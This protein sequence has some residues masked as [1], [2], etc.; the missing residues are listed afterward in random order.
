[1]DESRAHQMAL[2]A[3]YQLDQYRIETELGHGGF[4]ITYRALDTH[5]DREVAIKEYLPRELAYREAG[6]TVRPISQ[7]EQELFEWGLERFL[8]EGRTV[9]QLDH[10]ADLALIRRLADWPRQVEI[11]ARAQE[12]HR[13][14][15]Y[16]SELA[17]DLHT[18]WNRGNDEPGLRFLQDDAAVSGAK[19]AL[20]RATGVVISTGLA[21]LG[22]EPAEEMR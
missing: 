22:V 5:L 14:A 9:A 19:L 6:S 4:G 7:G 8:D 17:G 2:P 12:P 1:M 16:L 11:A 18:H 21:I 15:A 3:G 10:P 20:A 13:I